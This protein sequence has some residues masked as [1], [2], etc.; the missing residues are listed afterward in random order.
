MVRTLK[1]ILLRQAIMNIKRIFVNNKINI[2][3]T[4]IEFYGHTKPWGIFFPQALIK[5]LMAIGI[6]NLIAPSTLALIAVHKHNAASRSAK[7]EIKVQHSSVG[8][9]P[10]TSWTNPNQLPQTRNLSVSLGHLATTEGGIEGVVFGGHGTT[11]WDET[12]VKKNMLINMKI[13]AA[14][15]LLNAIVF[16]WK[17]IK[18]KHMR[19]FIGKNIFLW[20]SLWK[21]YES[22]VWKAWIKIFFDVW[23]TL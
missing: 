3:D 12:Q 20:I 15:Q 18:W 10:T 17:W 7:P 16:H 5:K 8:G 4:L 21:S 13:A 22:M 2:N 1:V 9:V 23:L 19:N 14:S 6:L 11:L